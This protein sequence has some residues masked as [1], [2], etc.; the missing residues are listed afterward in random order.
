MKKL[1]FT[2]LIG[3]SVLAPSVAAAEEYYCKCDTAV[4]EGGRK[5]LGGFSDTASAEAACPLCSKISGDVT[6][7]VDCAVE[8]DA[9]PVQKTGG[10]TDDS[11]IVRLEN[12]LV[13]DKTDVKD[14]LGGALK[15]VLGLMGGLVLLLI[16]YGGFV[17]LTSAGNPEKV[18]KGGN[19]IMWA[20][21]GAVVVLSSYFLLSNVLKLLAG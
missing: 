18:K 1:F 21:L 17:W 5:C 13:G 19:M 10:T 16:V 20:V 4:L 9:L 6:M 11:R 12:P 8:G 2:L 7:D 15:T 3:L 14:I